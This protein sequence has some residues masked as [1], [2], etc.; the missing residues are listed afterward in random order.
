MNTIAE[1]KSELRRQVRALKRSFTAEQLAAKSADAVQH[2]L[3]LPQ[4]QA[5][6][7]VMLYYSLPDEVGTH[8]LVAEVA[9]KKRVILPTVV[10]DDII[11]VEFKPDTTMHEGDFHILEP[12]AERYDSNYDLIVIPGMAF[13]AQGHRLG[14][15]KGYYDRFLAQHAETPKVGICFD[16]QLMPEVPA[17]T[18]DKPVDC[19]VTN[20]KA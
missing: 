9:K 8:T 17:D 3:A 5:A 6:K 7:T 15:G 1:Q 13:D 20:T 4:F 14:R 10:G 12:E 19:V 16:F 2:L 11:P 18:F